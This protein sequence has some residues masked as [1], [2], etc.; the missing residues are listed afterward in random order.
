MPI[1]IPKVYKVKHGFSLVE[2]SIVLV[3]LGLLT[4]GILAGQ[5]LIRA[6]ELRSVSAQFQSYIT[7]TNTFRDKY[8]AIPG[9]MRNATAFWGAAH[10]T[11]ATCLTAAGTGTQTCN[12][13]GNGQ[14]AV[15]GGANR[16]GEVF[17]FW[18]HLS[19]AGLVEGAYTGRAGSSSAYHTTAGTNS[20]AGKLASSMWFTQYFGTYSGH[21]NVFDGEL[22]NVLYLGVLLA[23]A[24]NNNAGPVFTPEEAWNIDT[25][26]DD[27]QPAF[28]QVMGTKNTN[29]LTPNCT[30]SDTSSSEYNV[31]NVSKLCL[32]LFANAY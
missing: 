1:N 3:I 22:G 30:T 20:P 12:G 15:G 8:F 10:A 14:L 31:S 13:D 18:Q 9:D 19:S 21:A 7:A 28:G 2:L 16:Y 29:P 24:G 5:N 23:A 26:M 25:K 17:T 6:A 4:G 27:G 11:P 32:L